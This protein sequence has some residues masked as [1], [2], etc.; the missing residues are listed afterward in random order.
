MREPSQT[1]VI[2]V[3]LDQHAEIR[4]LFAEVEQRR[5]QPRREAFEQLVRLLAV[6][7]TAEQEVL[8]PQVRLL[9]AGGQVIADARLEEER[10]AKELLAQ[11]DELG[12]EA[13]DFDQRLDAVR[14]AVLDHARHE[15]REEFPRLQDSLSPV[16]LEAMGMAVRMAEATAP[17]HPHPGVNSLAGNLV[18]GPMLAFADR[19][20][21]LVRDALRR[22]RGVG[23]DAAEEARKQRDRKRPER[24]AARKDDA[25]EG[26][27]RIQSRRPDRRT[28]EQRSVQE[29]RER[30]RTL[31]IPGRSSMRKDELVAALRKHSK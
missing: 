21:D 17:T 23:V 12:P 1:D 5:G 8:H 26:A 10:H 9:V 3:L 30:A 16:Q 31:Q 27:P 22:T 19:T 29:L 11:L 20:R 13:E 2:A 28:L 4:R 24:S 7:E 14:K 18:A 15:E 6:H 25:R